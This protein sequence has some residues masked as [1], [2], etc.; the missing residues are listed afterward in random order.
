[1]RTIGTEGGKTTGRDIRSEEVLFILV[2]LCL[3]LFLLSS[4]FLPSSVSLDF[5]NV[6][7]R[8]LG[9]TTGVRRSLLVALLLS[10]VDGLC[11]ICRYGL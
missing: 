2:V 7:D 10:I 3:A 1:M 4:P 5:P 11:C 8:G 6:R 9:R